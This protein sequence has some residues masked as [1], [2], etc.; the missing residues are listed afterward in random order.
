[1][2]KSSDPEL[3]ALHDRLDE[4]LKADIPGLP[5]IRRRRATI[6]KYIAACVIELM[7]RAAGNARAIDAVRHRKR[8]TPGERAQ[9][10]L[11]TRE[12]GTD[13]AVRNFG[14]EGVR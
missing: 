10:N 6:I 9:G 11:F 7:C 2:A 5:E 13:P 1:M 14:Q 12:H 3:Q 4:A 8:Y